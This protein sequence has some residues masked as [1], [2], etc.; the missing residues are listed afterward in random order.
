MNVTVVKIVKVTTVNITSFE[1]ATG[2]KV[3]ITV[4]TFILM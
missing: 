1:L 2:G 3:T 4:V